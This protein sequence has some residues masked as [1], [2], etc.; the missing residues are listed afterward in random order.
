MPAEW[1]SIAACL[2][3]QAKK[4][5]TSKQKILNAESFQNELNQSKIAFL[6]MAAANL[7]HWQNHPNAVLLTMFNRMHGIW[8]C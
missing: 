1:K 6:A 7:N 3:A 5:A 4:S 8:E 2:M